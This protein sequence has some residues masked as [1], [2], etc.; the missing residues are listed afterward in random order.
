LRL[1]GSRRTDCLLCGPLNLDMVDL[2]C[3]KKTMT[4]IKTIRICSLKWIDNLFGKDFDLKVIHL[5]RD[6]R[7]IARSRKSIHKDLS[8]DELAKNITNMCKNQFER[9]W[10]PLI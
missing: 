7:A 1:D 9:F 2:A 4:A 3:R 10:V 6:P 5:I 8:D